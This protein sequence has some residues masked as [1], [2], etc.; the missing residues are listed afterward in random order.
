MPTPVTSEVAVLDEQ[1]RR[2]LVAARAELLQQ[3]RN[4]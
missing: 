2:V 3:R 1:A 4:I